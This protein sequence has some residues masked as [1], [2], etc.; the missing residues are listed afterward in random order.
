MAGEFALI[1]KYFTRPTP[2]AVLG[3][4]DDCA[5][6]QPTPGKQLAVTTDMLVAGTH[7]LPDTDPRNLGWKALA[8][9]LSDLAAMGATP[10]WV[11]LAGS[12]PNADEAWLAA[13]ARGFFALAKQHAVD[14]IGGDTTR[15]PR[16]FCVT[17]IGEVPAGQALRRDGASA[18]DELWVSGVPGRAGLGLQHLLGKLSL[19]GALRDLCLAAL[20]RPQPRLELGLALRGVASAAIDVSDGLLGDL[21][22]L[23][24]RSG[25][26]ATV[27]PHLLPGVLDTRSATSLAAPSS[28]SLSAA[29]ATPWPAPAPSPLPDATAGAA[30]QALQ[31]AA[32]RAQLSGGDDYE[33]IFAAPAEK[34]RAVEF[35]ASTLGLPLTRFGRLGAAA[36]GVPQLVLIDPDGQPLPIEHTGYDHFA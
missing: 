36:P 4:G 6:L 21:S 13:F 7:F 35:I 14:V 10:R 34:W 29:R 24:E 15:G 23:L 26:A 12:L 16:N 2:S 1:D 11:L 32:R 9:N 3:P 20:H 8:V 5:L 17:A 30:D 22:H 33:L 27:S 18:G 31:G 19:S 25:L 28:A